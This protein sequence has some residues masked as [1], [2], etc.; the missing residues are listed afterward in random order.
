MIGFVDL[1][2]EIGPAWCVKNLTHIVVIILIL[3]LHNTIRTNRLVGLQ[4]YRAERWKWT[5]SETTDGSRM[6]VNM[7]TTVGDPISSATRV[8]LAPPPSKLT[9]RDCSDLAVS[10]GYF[11]T[12]SSC[13]RRR[14]VT[15]IYTSCRSSRE[16]IIT[17]RK[18]AASSIMPNL[19]K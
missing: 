7:W 5:E 6:R 2:P 13:L 4:L 14:R 17:V 1:E 3:C 9:Q 10:D 16:H 11:N 19:R 8:I 18:H 12:V 15:F